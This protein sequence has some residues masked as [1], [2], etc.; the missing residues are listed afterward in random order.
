MKIIIAGS[1]SFGLKTNSHGLVRMYNC[2][3]VYFYFIY[4]CI[5][6]NKGNCRGTVAVEEKMA[7]LPGMPL[8]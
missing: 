1:Y 4:L 2:V 3:A 8:T 7:G 6:F 5:F